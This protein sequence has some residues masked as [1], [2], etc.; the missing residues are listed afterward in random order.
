MKFEFIK[1][2]K[3]GFPQKGRGNIQSNSQL[4]ECNQE[5]NSKSPFTNPQLHNQQANYNS[6]NL[7]PEPMFINSQNTITKLD[8]EIKRDY[9]PYMLEMEKK[10]NLKNCY[11]VSIAGLEDIQNDQIQI[12]GNVQAAE[13]VK[14]IL[15]DTVNNLDKF[16]I[17]TSNEKFLRFMQGISKKNGW[18]YRMQKLGMQVHGIQI[19]GT[20]KSI[21]NFQSRFEIKEINSEEIEIQFLMKIYGGKIM[22][23]VKEAKAKIFFDR[24]SICISGVSIDEIYGTIGSMLQDIRYATETFKYTESTKGFILKQL[25]RLKTTLL[26]ESAVI[27]DVK[28]HNG[29]LTVTIMFNNSTSYYRS[30]EKIEAALKIVSQKLPIS[31][32]ISL[33]QYQV[34][35][36]NIEQEEDV[37]IKT[38]HDKFGNRSFIITGSADHVNSAIDRIKQTLE[39]DSTYY[40]P[41]P[42]FMHRRIINKKC[43]V[44]TSNLEKIKKECGLKYLEFTKL[45]RKG[46][47]MIGKKDNIKQAITKFDKFVETLKN[48]IAVDII[49]GFTDEMTKKLYDDDKLL[50]EV[51]QTLEVDIKLPHPSDPSAL[52]LQITNGQYVIQVRHGDITKCSNADVLVNSANG[53]MN[54][55]GGVAKKIRYAMKILLIFVVKK[56]ENHLK[57]LAKNTWNLWDLL[58]LVIYS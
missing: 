24:K 51:R 58:K 23:M 5:N 14:K 40:Y 3:Q 11:N 6:Y 54:H 36:K 55:Q 10:N 53:E 7:G 37:I 1:Q 50:R 17:K 39:G 25:E 9:K 43:H 48:V 4:S 18:H 29:K 32:N 28:F 56:Q 16:S 33:R 35:L 20:K 46:I 42:R 8:L 21:F 38:E 31:S 26:S 27:I 47:K 30:K 57:L 2:K 34:H 15:I 12:F 49:E 41:V 52:K 45:D 13:A 19:V 22:K 44:Y